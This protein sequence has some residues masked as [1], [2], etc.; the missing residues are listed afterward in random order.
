MR[1]ELVVAFFFV[2]LAA[3]ALVPVFLISLSVYDGS[4]LQ[5]VESLISD[6]QEL[7]IA[8]GTLFLVAGL[9]VWNSHLSNV[10]V[11]KR[12][13]ANRILQAELK[14]ADF[15][16]AWIGDLRNELEE[17]Y[18]MAFLA[19]KSRDNPRMS[20]LLAKIRMRLNMSEKAAHELYA[21]MLAAARNDHKDMNAEVEA[22]HL[23]SAKANTFL[24]GEWARMKTD[25]RNA[26]TLE[27]NDS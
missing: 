10:S 19:P 11:E 23:L 16:Q 8:L 4:I 2:I 24:R 6:R 20:S 7:I 25:I 27:E 15:R 5:R 14:V 22:L 18:K 21:A 9:S 13:N 17:F 3:I 12:D 1:I 26:L